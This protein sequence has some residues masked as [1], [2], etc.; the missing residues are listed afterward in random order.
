MNDDGRSEAWREVAR[1]ARASGGIRIASLLRDEPARAQRLS[2]DAAGLHLDLTRHRLPGEALDALLAL[3][4]ASSLESR[5]DAMYA[6]EEV[7]FTEQRPALHVALRA[8]AG[9]AAGA[10]AGEGIAAEVAATLDRMDRFSEAVRSG[11]WRGA[12]GQPISH[13]VHIGIG[14]SH[15]GPQLACEALI[16]HAHP[17][18][19]FRFLS[20][21]DPRAFDRAVNGLDPA[22][23]LA[24][25]ASKSWHTLETARN[26]Q[27]LRRWFAAGGIGHGD[28]HRHLVGITANLEA[29]RAF[30]LAPE[31]L[32]PFRD[33]VGGRYSLWS[34]IGLPA[35]L[36]A[37]P[38]RFRAMLAGAH[39][40]DRHFAEAP[41]AANAPVLLALV[42]LWNT[43]ALPGATEV[44]VP[45]SDAL[46]SLTAWLQQLQMESNG[47]RVGRDGAPVAWPTAPVVW[48]GPGTDVQH[49]FFQALHQGTGVHPVEFIVAVPSGPDPEGRG[50]ALLASALGQREAL[51]HGRSG[52]DA[53][54][55]AQGAPDAAAGQAAAWLAAH[56]ACPGNRP[57]SLILL[58]RL[59]AERFGALLALYEHKTA[60]LG[61]LWD[62]DSFD[63]WGV[64]LGKQLAG[65]IEPLLDAA[66]ELP[67]QLAPDL[68]ALLERIRATRASRG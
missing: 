7:N 23:T 11:E 34:A 28:L 66:R 4:R 67:A 10:I 36:S 30:G 53:P 21:V 55:A 58:D 62:I 22:T 64:E 43:L 57:S 61:W 56:R 47:K 3:A 2:L 29:A 25:V 1:R 19:R 31:S 33:W 54:A 27:A 16:D 32:F 15:L 44:V 20:N 39:A 51:L 26:A 5:R 41:L 48:G 42:S 35:M 6:G 14:G 59:D 46:R 38:Q 24:I 52:N 60:A 13:V 65:E 37:G 17:R 50:D 63:Q 8:P 49:S 68:R 18:L 9:A 12:T 40:M 45:Y